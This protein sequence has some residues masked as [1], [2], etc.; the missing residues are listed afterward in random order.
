LGD[1]FGAVSP[2]SLREVLVLESSEEGSSA[3]RRR[4]SLALVAVAVIEVCFK[5]VALSSVRA[6]SVIVQR[7]FI[8]F[9][10]C[11]LMKR[12]AL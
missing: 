4:R 11:V 12:G 10:V 7:K 5:F 9:A 6:F 3:R 1:L 2:C 8:A